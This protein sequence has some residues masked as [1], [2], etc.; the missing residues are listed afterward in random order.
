MET[1]NGNSNGGMGR[2]EVWVE[3]R[4]SPLRRQSA[5]PSVEM[6]VLGVLV[7]G[8]GIRVAKVDSEHALLTSC[9]FLVADELR[10]SRC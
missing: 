4:I 8:N 5:P 9:A 6:T 3:K 1:N 7:K 2:E 10:V